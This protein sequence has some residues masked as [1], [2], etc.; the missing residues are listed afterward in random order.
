MRR[1]LMTALLLLSAGTAAL[2]AL[3]APRP[4]S[5]CGVLILKKGAGW[6][7][8]SLALYQ[9]PGVRRVA[10]TTPGALPRL[11]GDDAEPLL[12]ASE[13]RGGW[14]RVALDDA[15][16]QGWLE[17]ARGWEYREWRDFLPGRTVRLL[18]GLKKEWYQLRL[19]PGGEASPAPP[20]S[21]DRE[22]RVVE[23]AQEWA[24]IEAPA[25]WLRWRDPDGRLTV[26]L[27]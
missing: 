20:L 16:R 5:G 7:P 13:R 26:S 14:V 3:P 21:R 17:K 19:S 9:E 25:G 12:A 1:F 6:H 15:G 27:K 23:V 22:V 8:D 10:E 2:G 4:Y 24:R 11:S 18:P